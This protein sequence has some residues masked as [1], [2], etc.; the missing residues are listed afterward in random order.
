MPDGY[1]QIRD[2]FYRHEDK[3]LGD[4]IVRVAE[5]V[6]K[7]SEGQ[8]NEKLANPVAIQI[9]MGYL[10][11]MLMLICHR[12]GIDIEDIPDPEGTGF[13]TTITVRTRH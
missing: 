10:Q 4:I 13:T 2:V 11:G 12:D 6:Y 9:L 5:R 7:E 1:V 8:M 3:E